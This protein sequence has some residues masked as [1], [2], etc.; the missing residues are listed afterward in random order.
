MGRSALAIVLAGVKGRLRLFALDAGLRATAAL[1]L[2]GRGSHVPSSFDLRPCSGRGRTW[3]HGLVALALVR[4][5]RALDAFG[6]RT[7]L[8]PWGCTAA[9]AARFQIVLDVATNGHWLAPLRP[10]GSGESPGGV[11]PPGAPRTVREPLGSHGSLCSADDI[12]PKV[13]VHNLRGLIARC[14]WKELSAPLYDLA[15]DR[16]RPIDLRP[17]TETAGSR[18][19]CECRWSGRKGTGVMS[20]RA[21]WGTRSCVGLGV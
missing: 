16:R 14:C 21:R 17:R 5:A 15:D 13:D 11:S 19:R 4:A 9:G 2:S 12:T 7:R 6:L 20:P 8:R 10:E 18:W 3:E 1:S